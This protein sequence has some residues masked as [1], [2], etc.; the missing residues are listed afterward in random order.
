MP[1]AII[2]NKGDFNKSL[3]SISISFDYS[4]PKILKYIKWIIRGS[5]KNNHVLIISLTSKPAVAFVNQKPI[6]KPNSDNM[7]QRNSSFF[8][9]TFAL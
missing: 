3:F 7:L 2:K 8:L 5:D 4:L 6:T 9:I 1:A